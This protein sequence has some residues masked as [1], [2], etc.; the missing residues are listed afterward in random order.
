M[1]ARGGGGG[2]A[3]HILTRE[4]GVR[5]GG[6]RLKGEK[7]GEDSIKTTMQHLFLCDDASEV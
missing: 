3:L 6:G 2:E 1:I 7:K 5:A 4:G